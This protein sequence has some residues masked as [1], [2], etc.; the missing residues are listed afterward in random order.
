M[1]MPDWYGE[2]GE[3]EGIQVRCAEIKLAIDEV[4]DGRD[5]WKARRERSRRL[6]GQSRWEVHLT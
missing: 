4:M 6:D 2:E 3:A 1:E 5:E